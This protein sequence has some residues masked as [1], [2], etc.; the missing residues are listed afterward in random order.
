M[1]HII[2]LCG[3]YVK[4]GN[5]EFV[6][7]KCPSRKCPRILD[8]TG[9]AGVCRRYSNQCQRV[10]TLNTN[11]WDPSTRRLFLLQP[12]R[13]CFEYYLFKVLVWSYIRSVCLQCHINSFRFI[14][15]WKL[16]VP[17]NKSGQ[18]KPQIYCW[19]VVWNEYSLSRQ[20]HLLAV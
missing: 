14:T 19:L 7:P 3:Y 20:T 8:D 13:I 1:N 10:P 6:W 17:E 5:C 4:G 11:N 16:N 18:R 12:L 2:L 15:R 9:T